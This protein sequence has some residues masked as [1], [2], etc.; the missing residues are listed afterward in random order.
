MTPIEL[1]QKIT[2]LANRLETIVSGVDRSDMELILWNIYREK[3]DPTDFLLKK[4]CKDGF[5]R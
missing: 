3:K 5:A 4:V 1:Q 2:T